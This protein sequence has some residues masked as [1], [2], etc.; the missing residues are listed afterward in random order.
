LRK[1]L[2]PT[3]LAGTPASLPER[4]FYDA[5]K[6]EIKTQIQYL[7]NVDKLKLYAR[8][9]PNFDFNEEV[10][11]LI[12][13]KALI[14]SKIIMAVQDVT[15]LIVPLLESY[16]QAKLAIERNKP[17]PAALEAEEHLKCL[18]PSCFLTTTDWDYLRECPRYFRA[19]PMRFE[20]L[21]SGGE[22]ADR[23]GTEEL[24]RY[25][26]KYLERKELHELADIVDP[27]LEV[28]RWMLEE[29]RV[30][31]FAQRLGTSIKVSP[32]RLDKQLEKV[33]R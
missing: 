23:Q 13:Q 7:P 22:L 9:I 1:E 11:L 15:K 6:R 12:A 31:L 10:G 32:Q 2:A 14:S 27:E 24:N 25:W 21:R 5:H 30:S 18:T 4:E 8:T 28:F 19:V 16:H 33:R 17:H 29:Y 3:H 20:K 26:Q